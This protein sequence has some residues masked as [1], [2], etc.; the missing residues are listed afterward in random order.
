M[1]RVSLLLLVKPFGPRCKSVPPF[2]HNY[3]CPR[4]FIARD[5]VYLM[6]LGAPPLLWRLRA[7]SGQNTIMGC[8]CPDTNTMFILVVALG[9][10]GT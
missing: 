10:W 6:R 8:G 4:Q 1:S 5:K 2:S 9:V 7:E 3:W